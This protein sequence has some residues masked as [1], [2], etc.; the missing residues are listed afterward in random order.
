MSVTFLDAADRRAVDAAR[1]PLSAETLIRFADS[2]VVLA[3]EQ[4]DAVPTRTLVALAASSH[5]LRASL[6]PATKRRKAAA[7]E[8]CLG[9]PHWRDSDGMHIWVARDCGHGAV[10]RKLRMWW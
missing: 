2:L 6:A 9:L 8:A 1:R 7:M 10:W 5:T 3:S 4:M